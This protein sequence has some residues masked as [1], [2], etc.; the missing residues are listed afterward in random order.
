[1]RRAVN[2]A[3]DVVLDQEVYGAWNR[4]KAAEQSEWLFQRHPQA[5]LVWAGND[6]MAFGA[7]QVWEKRGGKPGKGRLVQRHQHLGRGHAGRQ[8]R[9]PGGA[10]R[11]PFHR[12]APGRW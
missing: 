11:R 2:E 1:M 10:C 12:C 5:R 3:G 7:M 9:A 6:L 8:V 4:E